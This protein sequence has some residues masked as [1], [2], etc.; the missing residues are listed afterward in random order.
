[1][2]SPVAASRF[3]ELGFYA[4]PGHTRAPADL[5]DQVRHAEQL[6]IGSAWIS[7]RFDV[8]EM[9]VL[10]GAAAAV[11]KDIYICSAV[12]NVNTRHPIVTAGMA[13]TASR[14]SNGRFAL[15]VGRGIGVCMSCWGVPVANNR[16]L[17][18]FADLM[19]RLWK[20][21]KVMGY[22]GPLGAFPYLHMADWLAE[23]IP[24]L[25]GAYGPKS[26]EL[27]GSVFDGVILPTFYSDAALAKSVAHVRR[28]AEMAGRDPAAVKV[29]IMVATVCDPDEERRLRSIVGRM[30]TYLQAPDIAE[31][32]VDINGW[33]MAVLEKFRAAPVVA[34]MRGGS[35]SVATLDE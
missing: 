29:W 28:G 34:N 13:T 30:A 17:R 27:A 2:E 31:L 19:R 12:T 9:G 25:L 35:D 5:L 18:E 4:L 20:G 11:T 7:E 26:L 14:L 33:D 15:G 8:K 16:M 10:V 24:L 22:D 21:E 23:D 3:P 6:G 1:M 32:L